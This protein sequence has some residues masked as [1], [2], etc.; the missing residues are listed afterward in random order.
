MRHATITLTMDIY[1]HLFQGQ[2]SETVK[3]LRPLLNGGDSWQRKRQRPEFHESPQ[4]P[5]TAAT[6]LTVWKRLTPF[7][8]ITLT[9]TAALSCQAPLRAGKLGG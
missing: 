8:I 2:E 4:G 7:A 3:K 5:S 6:L 1:G 9:L